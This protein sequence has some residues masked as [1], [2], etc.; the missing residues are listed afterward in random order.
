[1]TIQLINGHFNSEEAV[2]IINQM[3][4]IKIKFQESKITADSS[5]EDIKMRETRI[6]QLQQSL[7]ESRNFIKEQNGNIAITSNIQLN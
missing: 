4:Q 5:E 6:R 7:T 2:D 1:M 3:I